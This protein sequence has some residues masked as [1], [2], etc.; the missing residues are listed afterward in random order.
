MSELASYHEE[1]VLEPDEFTL[2]NALRN[3]DDIPILMDVVTDKDG[4]TGDVED[5]YSDLD[6]VSVEAGQGDVSL[7]D[8]DIPLVNESVEEALIDN[9]LVDDED[10]IPVLT[11]AEAYDP[12]SM[13]ADV[14]ETKTAAAIPSSHGISEELIASAISEVLEKRLPELVSDV[15]RVINE[16]TK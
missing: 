2:M 7:M 1:K 8:D 11:D 10:S 13:L 15:L 14:I 16:R 4:V 3:Q 5:D 12:T 6:C 9:D